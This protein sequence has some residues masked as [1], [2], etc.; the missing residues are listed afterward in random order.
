MSIKRIVKT[1]TTEILGVYW[2]LARIIIPIS[3]LTE[4]LQRMG[5][6]EAIA[7]Y[8]A[9]LMSIVG[10]PSELGLAWLT[11]MLVGIWGAV[12]LIFTLVPVSSLSVADVTVFSS[13][14]LFAHGLPIEQKIIKEVG[15]NIIP[16]TILRILGGLLFAFLLHQLLSSTDWLSVTVTPAWIPI[17]ATPSWAEY[18]LSLGVAMLWML[19]ILASL[20]LSLEILKVTSVLERMMALIAPTLRVSGIQ[21][22][23]GYLTVVGLFLGISFGAGLLIQEAR[24]GTIAPRQLFLSCVFMGFAHSVIEDTLVMLALGADIYAILF[25]RILFAIAATAV[26]AALLPHLTDRTFFAHFFSLMERKQNNKA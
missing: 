24:S 6:I 19:I 20:A 26:I 2:V 10:L 5:A 17:T 16:T 15:P 23:A 13:L 3:I 1:K 25:G 22:E 8:F 7:P 11:A 9:P 21:G 12:P 18:F 4:L 14:I